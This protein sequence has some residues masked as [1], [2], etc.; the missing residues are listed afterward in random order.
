MTEPEKSQQQ[1]AQPTNKARRVVPLNDLDMSYMTTNSVW[2]QSEVSEDLRN[3]L[4]K[5]EFVKDAKGNVITDDEGNP[6]A[7]YKESLW[8]LLAFYTRDMR[9]AN[10]S[11]WNG[12][13]EY[14]QYHIDLAGD[15]LQSDM[16]G[17]FLIALARAATILEL[18][19]SKGGFLRGKQNTFTQE[20][21]SREEG[22]QK[23]SLFGMGG[24]KK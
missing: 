7:V 18:S 12:E 23:K 3:K 10:L 6:M 9:L 22:P 2:G 19:Q 14:C 20:N 21:V 16:V 1:L 11:T 4:S 17:S 13:V 24:K 8:G 15:L 5:L